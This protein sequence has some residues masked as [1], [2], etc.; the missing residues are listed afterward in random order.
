MLILV[1][2]YLINEYIQSLHFCEVFREF[3]LQVD[4]QGIPCAGLTAEK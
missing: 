4:V 2:K 3:L 1:M